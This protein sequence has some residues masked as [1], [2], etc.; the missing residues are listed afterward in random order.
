MIKDVRTATEN[1][2][3]GGIGSNKVSIIIIIII[4]II[5]VVVLGGGGIVVVGVVI[6]IGVVFV[7]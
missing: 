2:G 3:I 5:V 7:F 6:V 1:T 4:I